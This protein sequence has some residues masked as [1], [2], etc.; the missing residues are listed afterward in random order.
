MSNIDG[1][2]I[3]AIKV[4]ARGLQLHQTRK[5][6]RPLRSRQE[7]SRNFDLKRK[8]TQAATRVHKAQ[9]KTNH[10]SDDCPNCR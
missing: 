4:L 6:K 9:R 7:N 8:M 5:M 3:R 2:I 1:N 10:F